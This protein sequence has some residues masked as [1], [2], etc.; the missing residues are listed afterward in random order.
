MSV[1]PHFLVPVNNE[2]HS[3][4]PLRP[5]S[6]Y[7]QLPFE[8]VEALNQTYFLHLLVTQPEKVIPPGKSLLSMMTHANYAV[9][10]ENVKDSNQHSDAEANQQVIEKKV[11]EVV[12]RAFWNEVSSV[13]I[14]IILGILT[15]LFTYRL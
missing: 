5:A 14:S 8:L 13:S 2:G 1:S 10:D 9:A 15:P 12:H 3:A 4:I 7:S 11:Q 6:S